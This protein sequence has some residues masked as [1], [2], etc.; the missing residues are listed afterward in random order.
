MVKL[1]NNL[2]KNTKY[3]IHAFIILLNINPDVAVYIILYY[4]IIYQ[5]KYKNKTILMLHI[6]LIKYKKK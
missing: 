2:F 4:I 6:I 1:K 3:Y 5:I